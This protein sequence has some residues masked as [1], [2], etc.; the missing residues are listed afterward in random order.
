MQILKDEVRDRIFNAA[1]HEFREKGFEKSSMRN[2][3][4]ASGITV[5]NMY[6][7]F[8]SKEELFYEVISP[9]YEKIIWLAS[10]FKKSRRINSNDDYLEGYFELQ[11]IH[12]LHREELL[13]LIDGSSGSRYEGA[14]KYITDLLESRLKGLLEDSTKNPFMARVIAVS[15][16]EGF[17]VIMKESGDESRFNDNARQYIELFVKNVVNELLK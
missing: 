2:I 6:R 10:E 14:K 13:I 3:A 4:K 8:N 17:I 16:V 12:A 11:K 15:I 9:A 1:L 5:G 7:Y